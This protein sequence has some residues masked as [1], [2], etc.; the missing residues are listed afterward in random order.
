MV[1]QT[2]QVYNFL[3]CIINNYQADLNEKRIEHI[4]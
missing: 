4:L 1:S 3:K 2:S